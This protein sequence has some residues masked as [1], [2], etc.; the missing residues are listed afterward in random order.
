MALA[1]HNLD[2]NPVF[3]RALETME[4]TSTNVFITGRAGTGKS[5]LL[6]Y[7]RTHTKKNV[8][9]LAPTGVAAVNI[10]GQTIHSFFHFKP[11]VTL[12][13][14]KKMKVSEAQRSLYER[15][16]ALVIDEISMVRADLLDCVDV[17]LRLYG[18]HMGRPFGGVQ[19]IF[20]GDLYQLPPVMT[21]DDKKIF[22]EHYASPYFFSA[23]VFNPKQ[24]SLLH[25]T[26]TFTMD[27]IELEKVYRQNDDAFIKL[28]N[29][30]R[31]NTATE[32]EFAALNKRH[33]L[34]FDPPPNEFYMYLTTTNAM[35]DEVNTRKLEQLDTD[36]YFFN[37]EVH[38]TFDEKYL[39]T[40]PTINVKIGAQV[41]MLN[42]D[43]GGRWINGTMGQ[44]LSVEE[45]ADGGPRAIMVRLENDT[46]EPVL[47]YRWDIYQFT[48]DQKT[49]RINSESVG[50]FTQYPLKL[51]WAVTIHKSQGKT[52]DKVVIDIGRGTFSSG[53]LYVALS[54]ATTLEG[55]VLKKPIARHHIWIDK[56]VGEWLQRLSS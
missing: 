20:I 37:G 25:H 34:A 6:H 10:E 39:P 27:F 4:N 11:D 48:Y 46:V 32:S 50:S 55:I 52:F 1:K 38:G 17:F 14:V 54:R 29:S 7:F 16:E 47:P 5:T 33:N 51:A 22:A 30:I 31:A 23:H 9:V 36:L 41:M 3:K 28:L 12:Q 35:A 15:L 42:N 19:M 8:V 44:V 24:K 53:Q 49:E 2:F 40:T 56:Q 45:S 43:V 26:D 18:P 13:K 21:A